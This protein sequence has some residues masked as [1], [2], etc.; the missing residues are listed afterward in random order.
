MQ[1]QDAARR[2][3]RPRRR[4]SGARPRRRSGARRPRRAAIPAQRAISARTLV[5]RSSTP[6]VPSRAIARVAWPAVAKERLKSPRARLFVALDL[7]ERVRD[8]ARRLAARRA[9]ADP[10]CGRSAPE[11]L[12]VTLAFLGYQPRARR[13]S[14]IAALVDGIDGDGAASCGCVPDPVARRGAR[15]PAPVRDR[16]PRAEA[17]SSSRPRSRRL[18]EARLLRARE[19]RLLAPRDRRPGAARAA[20]RTRDGSAAA[21][22]AD[23][24]RSPRGRSRTRCCSRFVPS[25]SLSTVRILRPRAPSTCPW[26]RLELP[27]ARQRKGE[28]KMADEE[29]TLEGGADDGART[30]RQRTRRSTPP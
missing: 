28:L 8:G 4:A 19:A 3:R 22:A 11:T 18:V 12:H 1:Q 24:R 17:R 7:P 25:G 27:H 14:A 9:D 2:R 5:A 16:A 21:A 10:P 13:S 6:R 23:A 15:P 20:R 30:R 29:A 26:P